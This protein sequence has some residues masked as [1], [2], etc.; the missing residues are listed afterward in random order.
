[1]KMKVS[2][3]IIF[4][5]YLLL[6]IGLCLY[7]LATMFGLLA[8]DG[9]LQVVTTIVD[10]SIWF[11]VLYTAIFGVVLVAG[12]CL[13]FFGIRKEEP[14]TAVVASVESGK[15]SIAISALEELAA[16]FIK[17]TESIKGVAIKIHSLVDSVDVDVKISV[18]PEVSIPEVT[19]NLQSGLIAYMEAYSG[20]K[21]R[22]ARIMVAS[23]DETIKSNKLIGGSDG[24]V[25]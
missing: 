15:I 24:R 18:L 2:T 14:K 11:K 17:Q 25:R 13:L 23:I 19:Q 5:I 6:V 8:Q 10:G 1:M 9:L 21:V 20:I 7:F 12:I 3:R 22:A 16:K 4:S